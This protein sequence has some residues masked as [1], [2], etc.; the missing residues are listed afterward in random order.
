[1]SNNDRYRG[2]QIDHVEFFVP[3]RH[4]AAEWYDRTLGFEIVEH[5]EVWAGDPRGPLM[6][7]TDGGN[8]MLALFR[9]QPQGSRETA[10][11]HRVAFRVDGG[12]FLRFLDR[13]EATQ[14]KDHNGKPVDASDAVD[15]QS[16]WSIYFNDPYGHR[17]EIT[18]YDH[19]EVAGRLIR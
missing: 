17:L 7:S 12:G 11:F 5:C 3:D 19:E 2:L 4:V 10:G 14:V 18:T 8:T 9:G 6:I 1:M 13:L 16:A 15:H